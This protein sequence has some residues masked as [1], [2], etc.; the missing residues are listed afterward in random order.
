[1]PRAAFLLGGLRPFKAP[2]K[3][4]QSLRDEHR[5]RDF[6][7][8]LKPDA[9][10]MRVSRDAAYNRIGRAGVWL[11]NNHLALLLSARRI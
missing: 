10:L 7:L 1:M 11:A 2:L 3:N 9:K 4:L 6:Q 5:K 8:F